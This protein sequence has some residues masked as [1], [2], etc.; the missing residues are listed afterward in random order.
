MNST[1]KIQDPMPHK[2]FPGKAGDI[3]KQQQKATQ[4]EI[5]GRH[6][7]DGKMGHRGAR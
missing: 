4:N 2:A 6:K 3:N 1:K 7:D 5:A